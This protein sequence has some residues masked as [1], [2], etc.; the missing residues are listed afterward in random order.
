[1]LTVGLDVHRRSSSICVL[2]E[3]GKPVMSRSVRGGWARVLEVLRSR[4]EPFQVCF[5]ASCGYG[6]L[7]DALR[8]ISQR[9][10]VAHP[11]QLRLIFRSRHKHDRADAKKLATLLYL[12]QIPPVHVPAVDVR[13]WRALIEH[14]RRLIDKRTKTKNGCVRR[15]VRRV[16]SHLEAGSGSGRGRDSNGWGRSSCPASRKPFA[17]TCSWRSWIIF[18]IRSIG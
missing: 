18:S 16:S 6:P 13:G 10:L 17:G 9:V 5:E 2:D 3:H 4:E 1:M 7:H 15:F 8:Q 14:R 12:D 11:G